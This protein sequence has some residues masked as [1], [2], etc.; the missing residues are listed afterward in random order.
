AILPEYQNKYGQGTGG[1][2]YHFN[3]SGSNLSYNDWAMANSFKHVDGS[4]AGTND[5]TDESW[6]PRLDAGLMI[7]QY[8][9]PLGADGLPSATP[10]IS[11][12]GN[13]KAFFQTGYTLD[14][15]VAF[16]SNTEKGSTRFSYT[17]QKQS[18][19]IP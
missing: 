1:S 6:G 12:P 15:N 5:N 10:W 2:E 18:G 17:N 7:P 8:N 16:T 19:T 4:G 13:T 3:R 9:S 11:H 14:N